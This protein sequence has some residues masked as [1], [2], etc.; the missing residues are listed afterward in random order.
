MSAIRL[1][2]GAMLGLANALASTDTITWGGDNSRAGY[3]T[4]HNMDPA[5]VGSP[6]FDLLW[7]TELPTRNDEHAYSQPLVYTPSGGEN[8]YVYYSTTQNNVYKIDA[9]TGEIVAS[10]NIAIPFLTADLEDC[11]DIDPHVGIIS[12][13]VIDPE[14]DTL[15]LTSKT[16]ADQTRPGVAQGRP[17]GRWLIHALDVNDLSDRPSFPVDLEGTVAR[18]S[19]SR[20]FNGGILN[21]R[22]ALLQ[23]GEWIY[24]GFGSHCVQYLF[25]GWL[26]GFHRTT[27]DLVENFA[28][29]GADVEEDQMGASIWMSGGGIAYDGAGSIFYSTGNGYANQLHT[30]PV[31]G[32]EPPTALEE[33]VVHMTINEDGSLDLADFFM[34]WEK[35]VLDAEDDD[36]GTSPFQLLPSEF[37]CGSI[38]RIG[39]VTGKSGKTYWL[40]MD[41]LGGYRNGDGLGANYLD[42]IIQVYENENSVYAGAAVYPLEGGYVYVNVMGYPSEAFK[43][44]C[45]NGS[46]SFT[47]VASSPEENAGLG[48][49]HGTVTSLDGQPGT[50]LVWTADVQQNSGFRVYEA[51]P[52]DGEMKLI[53]S[54]HVPG[55]TKFTRPV[56]GDGIMYIGSSWGD[57]LAFGAPV[58]SPLDCT[59][60]NDFGAIDIKDESEGRTI[61]CKAIINLT[62]DGVQLDEAESYI[63][64]GLPV[65]PLVLNTGQEFTVKVKFHPSRVGLISDNILIDTTNSAAGYRIQSSVRLT[66]TGS[67]ADALLAVAPSEVV[68]TNV[69]SGSENSP[70]SNVIL[71]NEGNSELTI[72]SFEYST[73]GPN[74][75]FEKWNGEGDLR[76]SQFL[77]QNI[78]STISANTNAPI[79]IR[80]DNSLDG[81]FKAWIR[82][83]SNGGKRTFHITG[84]AGPAPIALLEFQTPGGDDWVTYEPG[85]PFTFGEVFQN[86][87]S[88]LLFRITNAVAPGGT[89]LT[90][91]VSKPPVGA[92]L[93]RAL[94]Q[95]DLAEGTTLAPGE[96]Q[97][98]TMTCS[99]PKSQWNVEPYNGTTTW[100]MNTND[101][102]FEKQV[103]EFFCNA[104]AQQAPPLLDNG[105]GQYR[106][107]GCFKESDPDTQLPNR[108]WSE[109]D[110]TNAMCIAACAERGNIFCG[111]QYHSECWSGDLIARTKV[112]DLHCNYYCSGD[113]NTMCGG[114]GENSGAGGSYI[115]LFAD[116]NQWDGNM[117][118][119]GIPPPAEGP[120][121]NPG[122]D[123]YSHIGCFTEGTSGRALPTAGGVESSANNV[124]ICVAACKGLNKK[125]AGVE[126][127][128]ECWCGDQ[129][130]G[131]SVSAPLNECNMACN[132]D[133]TEFCGGG[134]RLNVYRLDE[135][136]SSPSTPIPTPPASNGTSTGIA[137]TTSSSSAQPTVT[138]PAVREVVGDYTFQ[139]CYTEATG[140]RA[141]S[142]KTWADDSMNLEKCAEACDDFVYFGVEYG[143]EC[144]CGNTLHSTSDPA[145]LGEC[146][147]LCPTDPSTFCGAGSR[148]QLYR[149]T[150][151]TPSS[152]ISS[153]PETSSVAATAT[154]APA[155]TSSPRPTPS[156]RETVGDKWTFQGCHFAENGGRSISQESWADDEMTLEGC[157]DFCD[158][159]TYFGV[160]YGREC[161]CGDSIAEQSVETDSVEECSFIC[162][163][164]ELTF[165]GAGRR[166]QLYK[167]DAAGL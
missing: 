53:K 155:S 101:P 144:Y 161:Y 62:V 71:T 50:G 33:A 140:A 27:G 153:A 7:K 73:S 52:R 57:L 17:A 63:A 44:A 151:S 92:G 116:I 124:A 128:G 32:F 105:L 39:M 85:V 51:I 5:I 97:T 98:A 96:S 79:T 83:N 21:Q 147:F 4:N 9:K 46:P 152:A 111:T 126:Y 120:K 77:L 23:V 64:S 119:P 25:T 3:Q 164:D 90:L 65:V 104:V 91:M 30:I 31:K 58:K 37:A 86:T 95:V 100:T 93:V 13:G 135:S 59:P 36:L 127:G 26:I 158:G 20:I 141:L 122:V 125:M 115:S 14:T 48:V 81:D 148:L 162:P 129:L 72:E 160:E 166:L 89:R 82:V 18:N 6:Q 8:Q 68:F 103:I 118:R 76:V 137:S 131:G 15:Y 66:G 109:P 114:N 102:G 157:A 38:K 69:V 106:Y 70:S 29:L 28:L 84:A 61:T 117:T 10:R 113:I 2:L 41:N 19:P 167:S 138:G 149:R 121:V 136:T 143:R 11:R 12:T 78:P 43:F 150:G 159:Y 24:V 130:G 108:L 55:V 34:P 145:P 67:S 45:T 60:T 163:G 56:F 1:V 35:Q 87:Y 42:K 40:D 132:G 16:Y 154:S 22:P 139:G 47:R 123:G 88:S 165:C 156:V 80:F 99:V 110:N 49:G 146:S 74:G 133:P 112:E 75:T 134:S 142:G 54:F 94:N 107:V